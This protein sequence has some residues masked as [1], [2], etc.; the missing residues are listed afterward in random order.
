VIRGASFRDDESGQVLGVMVLALLVSLAALVIDVGAWYVAQRKVQN[1]A[2]AA[3]LAAA[4]ELPDSTSRAAAR[5]RH[6]VGLNGGQ[7]AGPPAVASAAMR[8]DTVTVDVEDD[9]PVFFARL[10]GV[11]SVTVHAHASARATPIERAPAAV[12]IAVSADTPALVCG[13]ACFGDAVKLA[14]DGKAIGAGGAYAFLDL[15]NQQG[16]TPEPTLA[17]WVR[18]GYPGELPIG[19]YDS[20]PGNRWNSGPVRDALDA[21][22]AARATVL[23]PVYSSVEGTGAGAQYTIVGFAAFRIDA[24]DRHVG[25]DDATLTGAFVGYV[26]HGLA[27]SGQASYFGAKSVRLVG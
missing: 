16:A 12:P 27:G 15:A 6:F 5:G 13:G 11:D 26:R 8:N 21:L 3:A 18:E 23:L 22:A 20:E 7:L 9:A 14:Y 1:A 19:R 10:V 4:Y 24:W 25:E 2:D 17:G